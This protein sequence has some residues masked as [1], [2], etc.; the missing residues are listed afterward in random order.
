M[1]VLV[2]GGSAC[3]RAEAPPPT[4]AAGSPTPVEPSEAQP[5][6]R[7]DEVAVKAALTAA[8]RHVDDHTC[9]R[10][11]STFPRVVVVGDFAH[12]LGCEEAGLFV[13][14]TFHATNGE[15]AGLATRG[16][17]G[18]A[19]AEKESLA[20]AWIDE[21]THAFGGRF[22]T[23]PEPA[24][25]LEGSPEFSPVMVRMNK[26]GGVVVEG[27][28]ELPAGMQDESSYRLVTYRFAPDGALSAESKRT[29]TVDGAR[30]RAAG[31]P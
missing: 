9:V 21:V 2:L 4:A 27:W 12:D 15:V 25:T 19:M 18:A 23:A 8:G 5:F 17:A 28:T 20:R 31:R 1:I 10:W 29:F 14:R 6:A 16:F 30:L 13:D 26:I 24:F 11:S 3:P 7:D 22:V